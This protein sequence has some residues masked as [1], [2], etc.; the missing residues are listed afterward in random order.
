M[1]LGSDG[2]K[3]RLSR[4]MMKEVCAVPASTSVLQPPFPALALVVAA[5]SATN[6]TSLN[7]LYNIS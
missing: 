7:V 2:I 3:G 4:F 1:P 6:R 5:T